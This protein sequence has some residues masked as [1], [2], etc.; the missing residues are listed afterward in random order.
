MDIAEHDDYHHNSIVA[1]A[2]AA[3]GVKGKF[4]LIFNFIYLSRKCESN[5]FNPLKIE[6]A[7]VDICE[8]HGEL[9]QETW[10]MEERAKWLNYL[11]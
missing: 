3:P 2:I 4:S 9:N 10:F 6:T 8:I 7:G 11:E 1:V 5:F